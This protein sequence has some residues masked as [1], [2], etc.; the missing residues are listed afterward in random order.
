MPRYVIGAKRQRSWFDWHGSPEPNTSPPTVF[1]IDPVNTGLIDEHE[2][3]IMRLP[4]PIG[5]ILPA[6]CD[7]DD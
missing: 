7:S 4:N 3:P 1:D 2:R 6:D 5:F